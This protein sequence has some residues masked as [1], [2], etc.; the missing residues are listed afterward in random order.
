MGSGGDGSPPRQGFHGNPAL[1]LTC[2]SGRVKCG[3][4]GRSFVRST[5]RSGAKRHGSAGGRVALWACTSHKTGGG[6]CPTGLIRDEVLREEIAKALG[7]D[8]FDETVHI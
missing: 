1:A 7:T 6:A 3:A 8:E 2:L 4:C 5:R